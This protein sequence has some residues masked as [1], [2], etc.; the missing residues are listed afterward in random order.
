MALTPNLQLCL[1][2]MRAALRRQPAPR[3]YTDAFERARGW[4]A[5]NAETDIDTSDFDIIAHA[6]AQSFGERLDG[7]ARPSASSVD[8]K[9]VAPK[10]APTEVAGEAT[11]AKR[12]AGSPPPSGPS[13]K[14]LTPEDI[15]RINRVPFRF[16]AVP[17]TVVE[18][19]P[20]LADDDGSL[21]P[22]DRPL[23]GGVSGEITVSMRFDGPVLVGG[24][25]S[26]NLSEPMM[27]GN[28]HVIP[29]AT[30]RGMIRAGLEIVTRARLNKVNGHYRFGVRDFTHA[31]FFDDPS[32]AP[33][34]DASPRRLAWENMRAGWLRRAGANDPPKGE[35][36]S[37][38][39]VEP[40]DVK[41]IR[42]REMPPHVIGASP[43]GLVVQEW[44]KSSL[45]DRL[46]KLV[47]RKPND[48]GRWIY[49]FQQ[50]KNAPT[51]IDGVADRPERE[52]SAAAHH[53]RTGKNGRKG[54]IVVSGKALHAKTDKSDQIDW[55]DADPKDRRL[56]KGETY[57]RR[58]YV[59]FDRPGVAAVRVG[60]A[61]WDR[62]QLINTKPGRK[63]REPDG[64]YKVLQPTLEAGQ[65]IPIFFVG[66]LA[67][68]ERPGARFEFGLTRLFKLSHDVDVGEMIARDRDAHGPIHRRLT[69]D[70]RL[71][72]LDWVEALFGHVSVRTVM[73]GPRASFAPFYLRGPVKDWTDISK[74]D[75]QGGRARVA[76][77]KRPVVQPL[78][79]S[80]GAIYT[81][82]TKRL[83]RQSSDEAD[84]GAVGTAETESELRFLMPQNAAS[85][86]LFRFPIRLHNLLP[87]ELGALLFV[88]T[89]G[90]DPAKPARHQIGRAKGYGA[91]SCVVERLELRLEGNDADAD[92]LIGTARMAFEEAWL[93]PGSAPIAPFLQA[94]E[95][96]MRAAK[97]GVAQWPEQAAEVMEWLQ[98]SRPL[99]ADK[100]PPTD[101]RL[102]PDVQNF[103]PIRDAVKSDMMNGLPQA[104]D[105][106]LG[107]TPLTG[108]TPPYRQQAFGGE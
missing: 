78:K 102:F 21:S 97:G 35:I 33:K 10:A 106:L 3:G 73:M 32:G 86:L 46:G 27:L 14:P 29:G 72:P 65:R 47:A 64:S 58:E 104:P 56:G 6:Y 62:F 68:Q 101:R 31:L 70:G 79:A 5:G 18:H 54:V 84:K 28:T 85:P 23:P 96:A 93:T 87:E 4:L 76:G 92:A 52:G 105:R 107:V 95:A 36:D 53:V 25:T 88:L 48:K 39:V 20:A 38:Y 51:F 67:D 50:P 59:F 71:R 55:H 9:A 16:V 34:A 63:R 75:T 90:G 37:D 17:D 22:F 49:D 83:T 24:P 81:D 82:V 12:P 30:W 91:G 57:K 98:A 40:A 60:A 100:A 44:L 15:E 94:F 108:W 19:P 66:D 77:R 42:I 69:E 2:D 61:A 7:G 103:K 45:D 26:G 80:P 74:G 13:R 41:M 43:D 99:P 1:D 11:V 89:H 8:D